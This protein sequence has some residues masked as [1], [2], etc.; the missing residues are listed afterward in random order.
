MDPVAC[1]TIKRKQL[2][3]LLQGLEPLPRPQAGLE[4]YATPAEMAAEV[5]FRAY[6]N[7]DVFQ[8]AVADLGCGN[9]LF[10]LGAARLMAERVVAVDVDPEAV[11]VATRSAARL[12]LE[13]EFRVQNVTDFRERVDS[14]FMNPPFGG[15]RKHADRPFLE[16]ALRA[17]SVVYTFHHAE[18][19]E[20]VARRV[21]ALGGIVDERTTYKFPLPHLHPHHRKDMG[22]VE[23]D[24][25]R[26]LKGS[27]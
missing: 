6:G 11:A 18:T 4:Q 15:Q 10:A 23:V 25:Y 27:A 19:R 2:A 13:V 21:E 7:R 8:R 5:L 26:I 16:A 1:P 24:L 3:I 9:G 22:E 17:G 20:W 12:G 14:V